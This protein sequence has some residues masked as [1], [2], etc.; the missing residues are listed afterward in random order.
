MYLG[1][2]VILKI[3]TLI[4][5]WWLT[6]DIWLLY[7]RMDRDL[8]LKIINLVYILALLA[9]LAT[10]VIPGCKCILYIDEKSQI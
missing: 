2:L 8:L 4:F 1:I 7:Y 3:N 5:R 6:K 10:V 9:R